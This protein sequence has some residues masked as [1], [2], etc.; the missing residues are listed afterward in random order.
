MTSSSFN[1]KMVRVK[2]KK[3]SKEEIENLSF[4]AKMVRVKFI[5]P[6][7]IESL[8]KS[9][10]AKMVRVKSPVNAI[11]SPTLKPVSMPKWCELSWDK[12][13]HVQL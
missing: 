4:N 12:I 8:A 13:L 10:N 1:A 5:H 2:Y 3:L 11:Q 6:D 7:W 9:F